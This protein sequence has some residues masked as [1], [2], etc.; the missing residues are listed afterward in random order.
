MSFDVESFLMGKATAGGGGGT[1]TLQNSGWVLSYDAYSEIN[2]NTVTLKTGST[3][4]DLRVAPP[5]IVR[6]SANFL[7][8]DVFKIA[9]A[10]T[11]VSGRACLNMASAANWTVTSDTELM[12]ISNGN[13]YTKTAGSDVLTFTFTAESG[14]SSYL[15]FHPSKGSDG[16]ASSSS[17]ATYE[18][19]G[20]SF[21]GTVICGSVS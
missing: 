13:T 4:H 17:S 16:S 6:G 9:F 10:V 11:D 19:T 18:V 15:S 2:G 14:Y 12:T 8:G 5:S 20:M 21:N 1:I 7:P 3:S